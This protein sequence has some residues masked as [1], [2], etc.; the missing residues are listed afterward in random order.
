MNLLIRK[1]FVGVYRLCWTTTSWRRRRCTARPTSSLSRRRWKSGKTNWYPCRWDVAIFFAAATSL[2]SLTGHSWRM[3]EM[4]RVLALSWAYFQQWGHHEA[5]AG[6]GPKIQQSRPDLEEHH[7]KD[8]VRYKGA[9]C[10]KPAQHV[11]KMSFKKIQQSK[12]KT[13]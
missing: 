8:S 2:F 1:F 11:G 5:N 9:A 6:R 4:P 7:G 13:Q 10:H 3:A 12:S